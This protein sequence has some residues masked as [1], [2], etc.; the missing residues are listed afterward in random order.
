MWQQAP[1]I[2]QP[3]PGTRSHRELVVKILKV[4]VGIAV[5]VFVVGPLVMGL[6][7]YAA[8]ALG[9]GSFG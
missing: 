1:N 8:L 5:L 6:L 9:G 7:F 3:G 2:D 4:A